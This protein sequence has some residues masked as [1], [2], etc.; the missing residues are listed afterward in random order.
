MNVNVLC[1]L[2]LN[3][4]IDICSIKKIPPSLGYNKQFVWI[5]FVLNGE[6]LCIQTAIMSKFWGEMSLKMSFELIV[7]SSGHVVYY[8][9]G[10]RLHDVIFY[11]PVYLS[12]SVLICLRTDNE[13]F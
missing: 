3:L 9:C 2:Y 4:Q 12:I 7:Q 6:N 11:N 13:L 1:S 8:S 5:E 10:I